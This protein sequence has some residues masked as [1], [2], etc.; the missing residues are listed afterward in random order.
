MKFGSLVSDG[1]RRRDGYQWILD[2]GLFGLRAHRGEERNM[3]FELLQQRA[4][5]PCLRRSR[6]ETDLHVKL[7]ANKLVEH[8]PELVEHDLRSDEVVKICFI[9]FRGA[10]FRIE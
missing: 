6:H 4:A 3:V 8:R 10:F 1:D 7:V 5:S 9:F 2:L